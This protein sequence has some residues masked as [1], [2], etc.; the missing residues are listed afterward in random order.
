MYSIVLHRGAKADLDDLWVSDPFAAATIYALLQEAKANQRVLETFSSHDFGAYETDRYHV[1][2][3]AEQQR[4]GRN[5]WRLKIWQLE[6]HG[7]RRRVVYA[8]GPGVGKDG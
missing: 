8:L 4:K 2:A 6:R 3:W 7:V 1:A 5:L